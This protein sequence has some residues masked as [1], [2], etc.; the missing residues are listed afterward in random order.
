MCT[1]VIRFTPGDRWPALVAF[2]RD[3]V[4]TRTAAPP[5]AWWPD[6]PFVVGGRDERLGGTWL[7][8]RRSPSPAVHAPAVAFVLNHVDLP[9]PPPIDPAQRI[10]RGT[11]PL[12]ALAQ[13]GLAH[14]ESTLARFDPFHLLYITPDRAAWWCWDGARLEHA[15]LGAGTHLVTSIGASQV[16]TRMR[17]EFWQGRFAAARMPEPDPAVADVQGAWGE[18]IDLLDARASIDDGVLG[19]VMEA[20]PGHPTFGTVGASL[21][22]LGAPGRVRLDVNHDA[23]LDARA[24]R[25]VVAD[26]PDGHGRTAYR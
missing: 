2:V 25:Q 8:V 23:R 5:A 15:S 10:S 9:D 3:E 12:H 22:A 24:W 4:R 1:A 20:V 17:S 13:G 26:A 21:V 14:D 7:A 19:L 16:D 11:L 18:W 6:Q